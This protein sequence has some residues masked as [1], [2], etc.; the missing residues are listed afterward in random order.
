[1][2]RAMRMQEARDRAWTCEEIAEAFGVC[3]KTVKSSTYAEGF[4]SHAHS[5][6]FF[7][8]HW[9]NAAGCCASRSWPVASR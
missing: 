4:H 8:G 2:T 7:D 6:Q 9:R 1:M 5:G 3:L